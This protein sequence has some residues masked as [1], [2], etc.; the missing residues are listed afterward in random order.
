VSNPCLVN[1][2]LNFTFLELIDSLEAFA[3]LA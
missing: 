1:S 2:E 3:Q